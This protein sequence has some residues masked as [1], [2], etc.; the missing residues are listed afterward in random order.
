MPLH[1]AGGILVVDD[2]IKN[3]TA[4]EVALG[5]FADRMVKVGSGQQALRELLKRDYAVVLLDVQMPS[6]DGF[7]TARL[8]RTR[9]RTRHIPIIFVTAFSQNDD[10]MRRGY[11]LGAVDYLF[12]PI[13]PEMLRAKVQVFVELRERT[14]EVARQAERLRELERTQ[15]E[16]HLA[17]ERGRWEAEALRRQNQQLEEAD[18]RKDEFIAMLGHELR[19]PLT[20]LVTSLELMRIAEPTDEILGKARA[21]MERQVKHLT[22]LVDDL[23][24]VSRISRGKLELHREPLDLRPVVEQAIDT[25]R[26]AIEA[27]QQQ[28]EVRPPEHAVRFHAD[29]A[30]LLQ[31]V[32]NLLNNAVRYTTRGDRIG[33][34]WGIEDGAV[35]L[36]VWDTGRG[37]VAELRPRIFDMFVQERDGGQGLGLGL[38]LVRQLIELHGG[39]VE[40]HSE[41][42]GKGSEFVVRLP[43]A[44]EVTHVAAEPSVPL[45]AESG[46]LR[47]ALVEDDPD[48]RTTVSSLL[49][50]WGHDVSVATTGVEGLELIMATRPDVA[51]VDIGLPQLD[52]FALARR[53][54]EAMG[55]DRPRLVAMT[56]YGQ[57][58]DRR[59][60]REAGFD[61]HLVKPAQ[62]QALRQAL[63]KLG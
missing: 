26:G 18:R 32:S 43:L 3:L 31:V 36:R 20:P 48:V 45:Q 37:I 56:G 9:A 11:G 6:M 62:P 54:H 42:R 40:A 13:V 7:E 55:D 17:E 5:E 30:R 14:E 4:M 16:R 28:L 35:V 39:T 33:V 49:Q 29:P 53:V 15:A 25:C 27:G 22:R 52:G 51:L 24:E 19:N 44:D 2:D 41:G 50:R 47:V 57:E 58:K 61:A 60:T 59:R 21:A 10:D 38:T 12:K 23:L 46:P 63:H 8:I 1:A 34:R